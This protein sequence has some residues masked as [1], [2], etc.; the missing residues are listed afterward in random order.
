MSPVNHFVLRH[1]QNYCHLLTLFSSL[2]PRCVMTPVVGKLYNQFRIK[3]VYLAFM[4]VFEVGLVVCAIAKSSHVFIVG[5]AINGLGAAG[6]FNG[7]MLIMSC[8]CAPSIRPLSTSLVMSMMPVG[9][10]TGPI[11]AGVLT[12]HIGWR[13][14]KC[15]FSVFG[16]LLPSPPPFSR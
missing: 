2:P 4:V 10:M 14:C 1:L 5:R 6:Q 15:C 3:H 9:S 7:C 12:A 11:I 13:W 8:V 16:P